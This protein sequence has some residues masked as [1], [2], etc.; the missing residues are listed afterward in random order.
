MHWTIDR[1]SNPPLVVPAKVGDRIFVV[2]PNGCGKSALIQQFISS[3]QDRK[4][5]RI[6]AHRPTGFRSE[7]PNFVFHEREQSEQSIQN[8]DFD[9]NSRW[10]DHQEM[11]HEEQ[12]LALLD[13]R[14]REAAQ[15]LRVRARVR[16]G[17]VDGAKREARV[18]DSPFGQIN[19]LFQGANLPVSIELSENGDIVAHHQGHSEVY[20]IARMSDGERNAMLIAATVLTMPAETILLIDEV[21]PVLWTARGVG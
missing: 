17:D 13:L 6:V 16:C 1:I 9:Y 12:S 2:G 15:A 7:R 11:G 3:R 20:S 18:L 4:V 14:E 19:G 5:K 10:R 8:N 21:V